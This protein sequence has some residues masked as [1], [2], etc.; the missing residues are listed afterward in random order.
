MGLYRGGRPKGTKNKRTD[1]FSKCEKVG[2]DVFERLLELAIA[3][4]GQPGEWRALMDLAQY[5]YFKPKD[6]GDVT[7]TPEQVRELIR[8]WT[9]DAQSS[10]S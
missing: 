8:E 7:M 10:G 1:L 4:K 2:L 5:L 3:N 9:K 6:P